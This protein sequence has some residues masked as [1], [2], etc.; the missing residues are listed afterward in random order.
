MKKEIVNCCRDRK[1]GVVLIVE[2][3]LGIDGRFS[4]FSGGRKRACSRK[5]NISNFQ[6]NERAAELLVV[7][8]ENSSPKGTFR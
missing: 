7:I 4:R 6:K 3:E 5:F 8:F 1:A 2:C